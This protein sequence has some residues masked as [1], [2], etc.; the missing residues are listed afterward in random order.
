MAEQQQPPSTRGSASLVHCEAE[1]RMRLVWL[2]EEVLS[3]VGKW[4][5]SC[6][7]RGILALGERVAAGQGRPWLESAAGQSCLS[8]L[9]VLSFISSV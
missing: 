9:C 7:E 4:N 3:L 2:A 6:W 8:Q 5:H 1:F